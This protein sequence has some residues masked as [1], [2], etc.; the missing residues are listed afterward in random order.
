M[1]LAYHAELKPYWVW[2]KNLYHKHN[3]HQRSSLPAYLSHKPAKMFWACLTSCADNVVSQPLWI[4][5]HIP[6]NTAL[7]K[8]LSS[9]I[10]FNYIGLHPASIGQL[11]E[12]GFSL[13]DVLGH[14]QL[15]LLPCIVRL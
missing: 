13:E 14:I 6:A 10:I 12:Q 9:V 7:D 1:D 2:Q 11:I 5:F 3:T 4:F 8:T 15:H